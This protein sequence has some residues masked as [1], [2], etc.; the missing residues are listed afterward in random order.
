MTQASSPL[1]KLYTM[2][3]TSQGWIEAEVIEVITDYRSLLPKLAVK[4]RKL[5]ACGFAIVPMTGILYM[6]KVTS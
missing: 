2:V 4:S 5:N 1:P 6:Q 3:K